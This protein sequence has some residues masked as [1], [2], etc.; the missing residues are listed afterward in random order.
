MILSCKVSGDRSGLSVRGDQISG[1]QRVTDKRLVAGP[2]DQAG[3]AVAAD[4]AASSCTPRPAPR[5]SLLV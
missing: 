3:G 2:L 1:T 5:G 4:V